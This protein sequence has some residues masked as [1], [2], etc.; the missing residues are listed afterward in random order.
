MLLRKADLLRASKHGDVNSVT[1]LLKEKSLNPNVANN[2]GETP[3]ILAARHGHVDIFRIL[4]SNGAD[5]DKKDSNGWSPLLWACN[6][7]RLDVVR[8][9][10]SRDDVYVDDTSNNGATS[11]MWAAKS[12]HI[13][14]IKALLHKGADVFRKDYHGSTAIMYACHE[15]HLRIVQLLLES[16]HKPEDLDQGNA[17]GT[18]PLM[19]AC[20][21]GRFEIARSLISKGADVYKTDS[22]GENALMRAVRAG[23]EELVDLL[24]TRST[25]A[26]VD[27]QCMNKLVTALML[28]SGYGNVHILTAL[29]EHGADVNLI[30]DDGYTA[31]MYASQE[32]HF[33]AMRALLTYGADLNSQARNKLT[34]FDLADKGGYKEAADM[35]RTITYDKNVE[36]GR[37]LMYDNVIRPSAH[38][39]PVPRDFPMEYITFCT[40]N[41][42]KARKKGEGSFGVVY[43]AQDPKDEAIEFVVKRS[44]INL[45]SE[46][47][48]KSLRD[49]FEKEI[50]VRF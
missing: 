39:V 1:R 15:G 19:W 43:L 40:Q 42:I 27:A 11:L 44:K 20:K 16:Y 48:L 24:L 18:T 2:D 35:L 29:L 14:V 38:T 3:L 5:V 22:D 28:A 17:N 41:F 30:D 13:D 7:G 34:A 6:C 12:N 23:H 33:D 8:L 31:L 25:K 36:I 26:N 47:D 45:L 49:T 21:S 9:L 50:R 32:G 4:L 46:K 37:Q 10:L